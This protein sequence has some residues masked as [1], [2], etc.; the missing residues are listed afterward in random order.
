MR[1]RLLMLA[2]VLLALGCIPLTTPG[3]TGNNVYVGNYF[4]TPV[5]DSTTAGQNDSAT[6]TFRWADSLSGV[7]H[8]IVWDSMKG[9]MGNDSIVPPANPLQF[10]G[11]YDVVLASGRYYYH[12]SVHG[13]ADNAFGMDG[14]V[15][16]LPFGFTPP[17]A[18]QKRQDAHAAPMSALITQPSREAPRASPPAA[19]RKSQP[20][21]S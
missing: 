13:G 8:R 3:A 9:G 15:V 20:V 17:E 14:Q 18:A 6:I 2:G 19:A 12:C 10:E 16:V 7:G 1:L 5:I 4:F 11:T 21:T